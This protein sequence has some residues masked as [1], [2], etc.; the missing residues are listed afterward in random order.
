VLRQVDNRAGGEPARHVRHGR[1]TAG[2]AVPV[3]PPVGEQVTTRIHRRSSPGHHVTE[4]G[5]TRATC[6]GRHR[7][8]RAVG[9]LRAWSDR[10]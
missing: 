3:S 2:L 9:N 1:H 8:R 4:G 10:G 5:L 7:G 6:R